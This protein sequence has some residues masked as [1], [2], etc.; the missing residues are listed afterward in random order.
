MDNYIS[1]LVKATEHAALAAIKW[2]GKGD[3]KAADQA[4]VEAMRKKFHEFSFT[5]TVIVGEGEKDE[6]PMLFSGETLGSGAKQIEIAV[7]PLECTNF[8][9]EGKD[10][11]MSVLAATPKDCIQKVPGTY[12]DQWVVGPKAKG[13]LD[14]NKSIEENIKAIAKKLNKPMQDI[15]V[16]MLDRPRHT[17]RIETIRKL[18]CKVALHQ[19]GSIANALQVCF[20][21]SK[22]DVRMSIDGAPEGIITA[23][24][25]KALGG[26]MLTMI[27]PHKEKFEKEAKELGITNKILNAEDLVKGNKYV[28]I[29]TGI[30]TG[31]FIEGIKIKGKQSVT[32]YN[33]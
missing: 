12:M 21:G 20:G 26:Q 25:V 28:F 17:E 11:S 10:N 13:C 27:K 19:R 15:I 14:M 4:A 16:S 32:N 3:P 33:Q 7:D 6:A 9:A 2:F 8:C 29:A 18:G 22:I 24:G 1:D 23:A 30:S 31:P 5:T